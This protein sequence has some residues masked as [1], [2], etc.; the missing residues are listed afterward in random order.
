MYLMTST[1]IVSYRCIFVIP[2]SSKR[3]C[4]I[5]EC[6]PAMYVG[7]DGGGGDIDVSPMDVVVGRSPTC[8][9]P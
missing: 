2:S 3:R 4:T 1:V 7:G 8:R 9:I 6:F 5:C